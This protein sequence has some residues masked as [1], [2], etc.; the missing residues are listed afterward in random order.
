MPAG[1]LGL[2]LSLVVAPLGLEILVAGRGASGF[3]RLSLGVLRLVLHLVVDAHGRSPHRGFLLPFRTASYPHGEG[4]CEGPV[5][6]ASTDWK[7][8]ERGGRMA[9]PDQGCASHRHPVS[10]DPMAI[11]PPD[12]LALEK[13]ATEEAKPLCGGFLLSG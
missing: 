13:L 6:P 4:A 2:G 5:L 3:L 9:G 11:G 7:A 10:L 12:S 1:F 8:I